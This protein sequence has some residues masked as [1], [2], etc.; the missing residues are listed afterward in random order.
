MSS[1]KPKVARLE[2]KPTQVNTGFAQGNFDPRTGVA[3][4]TLN[5][6]LAAMRDVFYGGANE[7]LDTNLENSTLFGQDVSK[8]GQDRFTQATQYDIPTIAKDWYR[9]QQDIMADDRAQ[10]EARLA[11]TLFKTGSTGLGVGIQGGYVNPQQFALLKARENTNA[12]MALSSEDRARAIQANDLNL[13]TGMFNAG[14]GIQLSPYAN[15]NSIFGMGLG[16][17]G[18]GMDT[19]NATSQF[20]QQQMGIQQALQ[21][22]Q[23]QI[24]N[25]KA[26]GGFGGMLGGLMSSPLGQAGMNWATGGGLSNLWSGTSPSSGLSSMFGGVGSGWGNANIGLDVGSW[27]PINTNI[28][29]GGVS[30][31]S[32]FGGGTIGP[33]WR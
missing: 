10:E 6:E 33:T 29:M 25:A 1:K 18:M 27:T 17:E 16:I 32:N 5:P 21:Q 26:S 3:G 4:Y 8:F 7:Y 31:P 22:N 2:L 23:Q 13:G 14:Q 20:A 12:Q 30:G 19:L 11:D 9:G 15:A 28:G 24:N